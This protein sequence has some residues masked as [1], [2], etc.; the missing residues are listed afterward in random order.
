V[1]SLVLLA[2]IEGEKPT[3]K[4]VILDQITVLRQQLDKSSG[5]SARG[6]LPPPPPPPGLPMKERNF[7]AGEVT[8]ANAANDFRSLLDR[9]SSRPVEETSSGT[10]RTFMPG[11]MDSV[12]HI[13]EERPE[14]RNLLNRL[15]INDASEPT[16]RQFTAGGQ[17]FMS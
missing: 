5:S 9:L 12:D 15:S 4:S 16:R 8:K 1:S 10:K 7:T 14:F 2:G 11:G 13:R 6:A 3:F 17:H